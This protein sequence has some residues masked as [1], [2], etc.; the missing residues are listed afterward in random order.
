MARQ[1]LLLLLLLPL[2]ATAG[3]EADLAAFRAYF[4]QRFPNNEINDHIDGAY[5]LDPE[6]REQW[7]AMEDFP[8]YEFAIDDGEGLFQTPFANGQGYADCFENEGAVK[9][10]YPQYDESRG[11]VVTLEMAVN[12]CRSA[13]GEE[14]LAYDS[15]E[16]AELTAYIAFVSRDNLIDIKVPADAEAAYAAGKQYYYSRRGQ[17]NFACSHCHMQ[18]SGMKLRAETL[19]AGIG[20]VSIQGAGSG[21]AA[22]TI[23]SL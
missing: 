3:P 7:L 18:M 5:A 10:L 16:L 14:P 21:G 2:L 17:L 19:S 12:D 13:N 8:P 22:S 20:Q 15:D 9:H 23:R 4:E 6:K 11:T 1:G